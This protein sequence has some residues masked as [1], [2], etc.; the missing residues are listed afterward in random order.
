L[1]LI[2]F[3]NCV[4]SEANDSSN[5][6]FRDITDY[7]ARHHPTIGGVEYGVLETIEQTSI[8]KVNMRLNERRLR[9][10]DVNPPEVRGALQNELVRVNSRPV[11]VDSVRR[12]SQIH[13]IFYSES[14][15]C[16]FV[17]DSYSERIR[18]YS[19]EG[20]YQRVAVVS[21]IVESETKSRLFKPKHHNPGHV[22][23]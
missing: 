13:R 6:R 17:L 11:K 7:I 23:V 12:T 10:I 4:T 14:A 9:E 18:I 1:Q 19:E 8:R 16:L 3:Y 15:A 20:T 22:L 21:A 5:V 2:Q